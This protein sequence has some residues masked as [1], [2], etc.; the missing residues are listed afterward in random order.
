MRA[1][2]R[3]ALAVTAL[4]VACIGWA[5][6][7]PLQKALMAHQ[8][9]A[10]KTSG[11]WVTLQNQFV[12]YAG[13]AILLSLLA[14]WRSRRLPTRAEW[15]QATI[16]GAAGATGLFLQIDAL[17]YTSAS[18]VGFLSQCYVVGLPLVA[19]LTLRCW[20]SLTVL[21]SILLAFAGVTVL[22]GITLADLRPGRGEMMTIISSLVFM[23]QILALSAR[24]W[25]ANDGLQVC[26]AM[27][28]VMTLLVA[29]FAAGVGPGFGGIPA[30]YRDP[31]A[32]ALTAA[33]VVLCTCVPYALMTVWQRFVSGTEA[34]IIYCS[35]AAFTAFLC[36][37]LPGVLGT[38]LGIAYP[39]E[40]LSWR[41]LTGGGLILAG[42]LLVQWAAKP[43]PAPAQP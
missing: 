10:A 38:W 42:C 28:A 13:A 18:T 23:I 39:D 16:C 27:F 29:P 14:W 6:S 37:L 22:S 19:G 21:G 8:A 11:P 33:V 30:C 5:L 2:S 41:M 34:G 40:V 24:R 31:A 20:P 32:L 25:Q 43:H 7:F 15:L 9:L 12:R 1:D 4:L 3:H 36:L 35:E 26:W 17:N